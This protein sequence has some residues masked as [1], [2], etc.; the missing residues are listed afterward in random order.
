M[1]AAP[2][3]LFFASSGS[4]LP[5]VT[6]RQWKVEFGRNGLA[7]EWFTEAS[8]LYTRLAF[9]AASEQTMLALL[10]GSSAQNAMVCAYIKSCRPD[11]PVACVA[12]P[13][14]ESELASVLDAGASLYLAPTSGPVLLL[15]VVR[16]LLA[17]ATG[18]KDKVF[19]LAPSP[20]V[21]AGGWRLLEAQSVLAAPSGERIVLT[22]IERRVL[23]LLFAGPPTGLSHDA[24]LHALN[25]G[26][27]SAFP[28]RDNFG[29]TR[30]SVMF[31]R[32][33]RKCG[34]HG[35]SL[36]VAS[37]HGWGYQFTGFDSSP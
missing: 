12:D 3:V 14:D 25:H 21:S 5:S 8:D 9:D 30:L 22:T 37:V 13:G 31:S 32:L 34:R 26:P 2:V 17:M 28:G 11:V 18:G 4:L 33:R 29:R 36:P 10:A 16:R 6:L 23:R 27:E 7:P 19:R 24:L 20:D 35:L 15:A 1:Q